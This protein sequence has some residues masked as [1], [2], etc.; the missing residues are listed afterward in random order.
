MQ[1]KKR[2]VASRSEIWSG[3]LEFMRI[4]LQDITN[5]GSLKTLSGFS[6]FQKGQRD[7]E[8]K[9][10]YFVQE[11]LKQR[12][13][14]AR[15]GTCSLDYSTGNLEVL[16]SNCRWFCADEGLGQV[17]TTPQGTSETD[18][19]LAIVLLT[20]AW[21]SILDWYLWRCIWKT[22]LFPYPTRG[23]LKLRGSLDALSTGW[24][25]TLTVRRRS[26]LS[27]ENLFHS[28]F[29]TPGRGHSEILFTVS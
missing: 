12:M 9:V 17:H 14:E 22:E 11:G 16:I 18:W 3:R 4:P 21:L 6:A 15:W 23:F 8:H 2:T 26:H 5:T 1:K 7:E 10:S 19:V 20:C 13:T 28:N 24:C 25:Y 27:A 29:W